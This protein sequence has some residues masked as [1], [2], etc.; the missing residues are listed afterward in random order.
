MFCSF[1]FF[2][3]LPI[4]GYIIF[5]LLFPQMTVQGLFVGACSVTAVVLFFLGAI[6]SQ[7]STTRWYVAGLETLLLGGACA[8]VAFTIGQVVKNYFH[9]QGH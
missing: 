2:G 3:S 7:F 5:P 4:L 9:Q 8:T 6:K 1:A